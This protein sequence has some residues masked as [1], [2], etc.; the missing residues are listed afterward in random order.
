MNRKERYRKRIK[1]IGIKTVFDEKITIFDFLQEIKDFI[2]DSL[3]K[4][5]ENTSDIRHTDIVGEFQ[6]VE[7]GKYRSFVC[8]IL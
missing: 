1:G 3:Q 5:Q 6:Q 7:K 2:C 4:Y 8:L